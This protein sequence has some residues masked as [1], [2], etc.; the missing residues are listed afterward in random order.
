LDRAGLI[1]RLENGAGS[2]ARDRT[3]SP[4]PCS[5]PPIRRKA[6]RSRFGWLFPSRP[7]PPSKGCA[8]APG[9]SLLRELAGNARSNY[10]GRQARAA[11]IPSPP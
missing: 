5:G 10:A 6:Q 3:V 7:P 4:P 1:A 2:P 8:G 9:A 11:P